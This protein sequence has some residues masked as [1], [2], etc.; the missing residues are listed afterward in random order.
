MVEY[1]DEQYN[2]NNQS[3]K[4]VYNN[5]TK[6]SFHERGVHREASIDSEIYTKS[7]S[8]VDTFGDIRAHGKLDLISSVVTAENIRALV[9]CCFDVRTSIQLDLC[10]TVTDSSETL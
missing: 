3:L 5:I 6:E 4:Q 10:P 9:Q 8:W 2:I 7:S 1:E